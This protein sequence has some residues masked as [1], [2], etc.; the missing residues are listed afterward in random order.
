MRIVHQA[1]VLSAEARMDFVIGRRSSFAIASFI[2]V[3][4]KSMIILIQDNAI[5]QRKEG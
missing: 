1:R 2:L 3:C 4:T 5:V